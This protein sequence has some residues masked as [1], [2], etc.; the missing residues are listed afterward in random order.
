MADRYSILNDSL[1]K[2]GINVNGRNLVPHS[3]IYTYVTLLRRTSPV[4]EVRRLVGHTSASMTEYYTR[5]GLSDLLQNANNFK[6]T[7]DR[8]FG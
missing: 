7:V 3:L 2:Y 1:I 5:P 8:I 6:S 4:D